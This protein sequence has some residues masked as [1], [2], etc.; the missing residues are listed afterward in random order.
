[1]FEKLKKIFANTKDDSAAFDFTKIEDVDEATVRAFFNST[2]E[3][4]RRLP[5]LVAGYVASVIES[6]FLRPNRPMNALEM[7]EVRG[8][9]KALRRFAH[10]F[11]MGVEE[12]IS[13]NRGE[14]DDEA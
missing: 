10:H 4:S 11:Q 13:R 8:G 1:M 7:A 3:A 2:H 6:E 9:L 5:L 12:W 14:A